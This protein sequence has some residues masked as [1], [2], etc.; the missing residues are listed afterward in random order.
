MTFAPELIEG[1]PPQT[2]WEQAHRMVA[3]LPDA[4][5]AIYGPLLQWTHAACMQQGGTGPQWAWSQLTIKW[6]TLGMTVPLTNWVERQMRS[7]YP[8]VFEATPMVPAMTSMMGR[9]LDRAGM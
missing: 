5:I 9:T 8:E 1:L 7:H 2:V 3:W 4:H 6:R